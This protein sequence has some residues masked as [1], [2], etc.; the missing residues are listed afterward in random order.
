[1]KDGK[2]VGLKN[3]G[4]KPIKEVEMWSKWG[5]LIDDEEE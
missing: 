3:I 2:L 4:L 5:P 1:M